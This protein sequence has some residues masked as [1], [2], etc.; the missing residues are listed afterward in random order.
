MLL[1]ELSVVTSTKVNWFPYDS[2]MAKIM[3]QESKRDHYKSSKGI[4]KHLT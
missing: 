1:T 3:R 2:A 4:T